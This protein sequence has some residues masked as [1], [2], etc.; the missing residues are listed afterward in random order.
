MPLVIERM[1]TTL[2][3]QDEVHIRR[4]VRD[5]IERC[6]REQDRTRTARRD[7][8]VDPRDPSAGNRTSRSG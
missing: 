8:Q 4:L 1:T 2:E 5:E 6:L 7:R 3:I